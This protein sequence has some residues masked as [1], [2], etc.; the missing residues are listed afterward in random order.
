M[1]LLSKKTEFG[2]FVLYLKGQGHSVETAEIEHLDF[3]H[4]GLAD[5]PEQF[6]NG[7]LHLGHITVSVDTGETVQIS[8]DITSAADWV[9]EP[10]GGEHLVYFGVNRG[11]EVVSGIG[12]RDP[13]W[14]GE[15]FGLRTLECSPRPQPYRCK[16]QATRSAQPTFEIAYAELHNPTS[17]NQELTPWYLTDKALRF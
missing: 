12:M 8:L 5:L 15:Q 13:E 7:S 14:F 11:S 6:Q 16:F 4:A 17:D 9:V 3:G 10:K 2:S 1:H